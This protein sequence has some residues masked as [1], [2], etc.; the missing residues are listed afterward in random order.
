MLVV[1]VRLGACVDVIEAIVSV[2]IARRE[3]P[4]EPMSGG[5]S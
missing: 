4:D 2:E 1:V 3:V 5:R